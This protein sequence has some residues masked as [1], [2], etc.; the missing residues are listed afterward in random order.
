MMI[1]APEADGDV[2]DILGQEI[3]PIEDNMFVI[4][5]KYKLKK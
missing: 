4:P 5:E 3:S 2:H 1:P